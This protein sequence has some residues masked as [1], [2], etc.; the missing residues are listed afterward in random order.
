MADKEK[1]DGTI[2]LYAWW[3]SLQKLNDG[4]KYGFSKGGAENGKPR[5]ESRLGES[6]VPP[7]L[8]GK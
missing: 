5:C 4:L 7:A 2:V 6:P 8:K 1:T 3:H